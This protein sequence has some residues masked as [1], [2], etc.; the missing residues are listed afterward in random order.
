MTLAL[1]LIDG[2]PVSGDQT[3]PGPNQSRPSNCTGEPTT[4]G[5]VVTLAEHTP[6]ISDAHLTK[7]DIVQAPS[8][9]LG[10]PPYTL[11]ASMELEIATS[12]V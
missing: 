11:V 4:N 3:K 7:T 1:S 2:Q 6:F 9:F 12:R 10:T 8:A 5:H